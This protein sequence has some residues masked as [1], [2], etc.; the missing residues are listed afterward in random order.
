MQN[1]ITQ[2]IRELTSAFDKQLNYDNEYF[3]RY[4]DGGA[5]EETAA[6]NMI[7]D[8]CFIVD[9]LRDEGIAVIRA[10][11]NAHWQAKYACGVGIIANS[12]EE[13]QAKEEQAVK[14]FCKTVNEEIKKG[15]D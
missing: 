5:L 10:L 2:K 3:D 9:Y 14:E 1:E 4:S 7:D 11:L 8:D 13:Y 12:R 15:V 6:A